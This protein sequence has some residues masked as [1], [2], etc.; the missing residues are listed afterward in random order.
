MA[1]AINQDF[2][3]WTGR[4]SPD[5]LWQINGPWYG[6]GGNYLLP[7]LATFTTTYPGQ[8]DTGFLNLTIP[9]STNP[10][11]GAE[12]QTT[13]GYGYGEYEVRMMPSAMPGGVASFFLIGAPNYTQPEFDIEFLLGT[14]SQVTFTNHPG[15]GTTYYNLGFDPTAAFHTYGI[16]WTPGPTPGTA[17]VADLV[18][19]VIV[20]SE[21]SSA[22]VAPA[23]GEYIMMNSGWATPISAADRLR[24]IPHLPTT[25]CT[26]PPTIRRPQ[27]HPHRRPL[28]ASHPIRMASTPPALST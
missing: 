23:N 3:F 16:L 2:N 9:P 26:L 4:L 10:L 14:H 6:T 27:R 13:Q 20:H 19:G 5:G 15:S 22:Y 8:T 28:P 7:S 24:K 25:G 12:I 21:T 18:D 17:T 1:L 11:E